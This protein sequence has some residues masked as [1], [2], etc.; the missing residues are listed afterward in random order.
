MITIVK[1]EDKEIT[2]RLKVKDDGP[3]DLTN[4]VITI[5]YKDVNN[6]VQTLPGTLVGLATSGRF[7]F[8][9]TDAQTELLKLSNFEFDVYLTE[10]SVENIYK[11]TGLVMVKDKIR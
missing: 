2:V 10:G 11:S 8:N 4:K 1:G 9:L 3:L 6:V 7:K 5:K